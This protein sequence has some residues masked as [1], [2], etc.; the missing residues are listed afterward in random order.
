MKYFLPFIAIVFLTSCGGTD[1]EKKTKDTAA[2]AIDTV[3]HLTLAQQLA[4]IDKRKQLPT[5]DDYVIQMTNQLELLSNKYKEPQDTIAEWTSKVQGA[6]H[7]EGIE[8]YNLNI[9][10]EIS[11]MP[12]MDNTKF[13]DVV[14]LY[15]TEKSKQQ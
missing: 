3:N 12:K 2:A 9:L 6:L 14:T 8:D 13:K 15:G 7:D 5:N 1:T 11:K 4:L 10:Q